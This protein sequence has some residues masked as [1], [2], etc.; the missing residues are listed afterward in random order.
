MLGCVALAESSVAVS[1]AYRQT[2]NL[3]TSFVAA[4]RCNSEQIAAHVPARI[5]TD[6]HCRFSSVEGLTS[7]RGRI[8]RVVGDP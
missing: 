4:I 3:G 8:K 1:A 7:D 2:P 5:P 6:F